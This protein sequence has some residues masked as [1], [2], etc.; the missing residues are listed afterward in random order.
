MYT[1]NGSLPRGHLGMALLDAGYTVDA[2][3]YAA[4]GASYRVRSASIAH[5]ESR[6]V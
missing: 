4:I 3:Y 5:G 6:N 1:A 2:V